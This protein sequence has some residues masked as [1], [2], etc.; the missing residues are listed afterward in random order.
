MLNNYLNELTATFGVLY[1]KLHQYHWYVKG[2]SFFTLHEK[3]EEL[4]DETTTHLDDVAERLLQVGGKPVSTLAEFIKFSW[5]E[6]A[7]YTKEMSA[8]EMVLAYK[9]DIT[10]I[11]QKLTEGI[12]IAQDANDEVS[13]DLFIGLKASFEKTLWMLDAYLG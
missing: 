13:A 6:E 10:L 11:N 9:A 3:F 1:V 7:P 12:T 4:Y 2:T 8:K 5:V